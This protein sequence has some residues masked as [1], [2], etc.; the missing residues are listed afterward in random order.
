MGLIQTVFTEDTKYCMLSYYKNL[1]VLG[2]A[3][4][5]FFE[6]KHERKPWILSQTC[7]K[8]FQLSAVAIIC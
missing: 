6:K 2:I 3:I 7:L 4:G 8:N 5:I 1:P